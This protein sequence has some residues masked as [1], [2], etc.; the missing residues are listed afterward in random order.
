MRDRRRPSA[1]SCRKTS[2]ERSGAGRGAATSLPEAQLVDASHANVAVRKN[3]PN[4]AQERLTPHDI[5]VAGIDGAHRQHCFLYRFLVG[6]VTP[7]LLRV[8]LPGAKEE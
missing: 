6:L 3:L 5:N 7:D 8:R 2:C 4:V 1:L